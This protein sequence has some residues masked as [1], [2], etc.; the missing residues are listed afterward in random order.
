MV[1]GSSNSVCKCLTC[2]LVLFCFG[3]VASEV[4]YIVPSQSYP[5]GA[6]RCLTFSQFISDLAN[7]V[8]NKCDNTTLIFA[9]GYHRFELDLIIQDVHSFSMHAEPF[10][11]K[12]R[13]VC[14]LH[15]KFEFRNVNSVTV[16]GLYFIGCSG[17]QLRSVNRFQLTNSTFDSHA[18]ADGTTL[19]ITE[20]TAYLDK[21]GF[22]STFEIALYH[23]DTSIQDICTL[24]SATIYKILTNRSVAVISQSSF[25]RSVMGVGAVIYS[26]EGSEITIFNSTFKNNR[27]TCCSLNPNSSSDCVGAIV[28]SYSSSMDVYDSRFEYNQGNI[29]QIIGGI[30]S[31][32]HS[33]FSNHFGLNYVEDVVYIRDGNLSISY[34]TFVSNTITILDAYYSNTSVTNSKFIGNNLCLSMTG[35]QTSIDHNTFANNI[36]RILNAFDINTVSIYHNE[37]VNN[38]AYG[39]IRFDTDK[40]TISLNEFIRNK[41]NF[42]LVGT[43]YHTPPENITNNV[44]IDNSAIYDVYIYSGCRPGLSLSLGS[45]HCIK[46]PERWYLNLLG[47]VIAAFIAGIA[48]VTVLL[49]LNMTVAVGTLNGILFYANI[50]AANMEAYFP[51]SSTPNF[52]TVFISWLNLDIGFDICF[53]DGMNTETKA[54]LQLAFPAYV[55]SLVIIIIVISE[56]SSKF[57]KIVGKGDAVAVLAT[58]ILLS[59]TKFFKAIIGSISLL[60][61]LPGYGSLN[62]DPASSLAFP[63]ETGRQLRSYTGI[64][65][66]LLVISPFVFLVGLLYTALVFSW[67]WL[68]R[69]QDKAILKCVRYQKLQH[70]MEPYHASYT[71]KY[72]YWTGLL[73]IARIA[74]FGVSAINFSR[75]PRVDYISNIFI[76]GYL[77]LFKGVVAQ[78][79][80]KNTLIDVMETAIYFNLVIFAAFTWYSMDFGGNQEA[81][82]Y[83]SVMIT[84]TLLL[85]VIIFHALRFTS[86]RKLSFVRKSLQWVASK[87]TDKKPTQEN[88]DEDEPEELDGVLLQRARQPY[89][90]YSVFQMSQN[91]A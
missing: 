85:A 31:F 17:N 60:Y 53:F 69:Y 80:Y 66:A 8:Y 13:I 22:L 79:I 25:E 86:L 57:A 84:F 7:L 10:S 82:A 75:D 29:V 67:Q 15:A 37:L 9:P 71:T 72:R 34:S 74:L 54:I 32:T 36:G 28:S 73:L 64:D 27:A 52:V 6:D 4:Y 83:I 5:C 23:A 26:L 21:V 38:T 77:I 59:Y 2:I 39:L 55:I 56:Y 24:D 43:A 35:G 3:F 48:L 33:V 16:S 78:R 19:T 90:S 1:Q 20:S 70:F 50:V 40:V 89:V 14:S 63:Q 61:S 12:T 68:I 11:S 87:L 46:C 91:E 81:V 58:M 42:E 49:V 65:K 44:F 18:E 76:V 88:F 51:L 41:V 30:V 47:L 45:S 62:F